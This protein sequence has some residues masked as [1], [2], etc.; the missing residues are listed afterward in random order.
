VKDEAHK[1]I[2][3][4]IFTIFPQLFKEMQKG[5]I[6]ALGIQSKTIPY[7][8]VCQWILYPIAVWFF[9]FK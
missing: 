1:A 8:L 4:F 9:A 6:M 5:I 3:L 7:Y 2:W